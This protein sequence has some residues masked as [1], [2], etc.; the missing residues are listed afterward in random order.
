MSKLP[1]DPLAA[2][3]RMAQNGM[4]S[5][6]AASLE[7]QV[8]ERAA[9]LVRPTTP[10]PMCCD[11]HAAAWQALNDRADEIQEGESGRG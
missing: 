6:I 3:V 10:E 7:K 5:G 4:H 1:A 11:L 2:L 9:A 8:W